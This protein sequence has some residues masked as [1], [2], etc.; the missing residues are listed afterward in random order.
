MWRDTSRLC[1]TVHRKKRNWK[2]STEQDQP[3]GRIKYKP[4]IKRTTMKNEMRKKLVHTRRRSEKRERETERMLEGDS[5]WEVKI[6]MSMC[7]EKKIQFVCIKLAV[8]N[9]LQF[10]LFFRLVCC[11]HMRHMQ[12]CD[13]RNCIFFLDFSV[14]YPSFLCSLLSLF[15]S[16]WT[17]VKFNTILNYIG[18]KSDLPLI[19]RKFPSTLGQFPAISW[20]ALMSPGKFHLVMNQKLCRLRFHPR[21]KTKFC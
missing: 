13:R 19:L 10:R 15:R 2:A 17:T 7:F 16:H 9:I 3:N 6:C 1:H 20:A 11:P 12:C 14:I 5:E 4:T 18:H 21:N 8:I